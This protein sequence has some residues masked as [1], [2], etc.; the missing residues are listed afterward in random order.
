MEPVTLPSLDDQSASLRDRAVPR[1]AESNRTA[2]RQAHA[3]I[4]D[5]SRPSAA[6]ERKL[7]IRVLQKI[8]CPRIEL[9]LWDDQSIIAD[10]SP[11]PVARVHVGSRKTL[12]KLLWDPF[13]EFG[14]EYA[15]GR[16]DVDGDWIELLSTVYNACKDAR[17]PGRRPR[18]WRRF[19]IP[20]HRNTLAGSRQNIHHHY[21]IGNDFYRLWLDEDMLYTC[22]YFPHD[23]M[24][25]EQ[26]QRAKMDHVCRKV[27]LQTAETVVE[28]GCG[29]GGLAIHMAK[30][31]GVTVRAFNISKEQVAYAR[32][33][34]QQEGVADKVEFVHDDWR[35]ITGRYDAFVSVGMLEHV[36]VENYGQLGEVIDRSLFPHGRGLIHTIGQNYPRPFDRWIEAR[37]FPGAYPPTLKQMAEIFEQR[38]FSVL[39]VENIRLHYAKTLWHWWNRFERS[40]DAIRGTFDERFVR[41][42]RLY[43]VG[44]IT[45]FLTGNLQ[46]FQAVFARG[47]SNDVPRSR[48]YQYA[49]DGGAVER[50]SANMQLDQ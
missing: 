40:T 43:L 26:A 23:G 28:A 14:E 31:Y 15:A 21:D 13:Y 25:L 46:L 34:A 16:I 2:E 22:A 24:S 3:R 20:P 17:P 45:S 9:V 35:N 36:G 41:M 5:G 29:W 42:W 19:V 37:I 12:W 8:G 11:T 39:D 32:R 4:T 30:H 50:F 48:A 6:W 44:S 1:V 7:L 27:W 18:S 38:D 33:R 10:G 47:R 49:T